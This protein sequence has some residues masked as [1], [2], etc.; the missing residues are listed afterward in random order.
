MDA[1]REQEIPEVEHLRQR[2]RA[3]AQGQH[4]GERVDVGRERG[5][6]EVGG[7][8]GVDDG[9]QAVHERE[10][11]VH[12]RHGG[13][14]V[15]GQVRGEEVV[16]EDVGF[17]FGAGGVEEGRG[18]DVHALQVDGG[19]VRRKGGAGRGGVFGWGQRLRVVERPGEGVE[20][21]D[22]GGFADASFE[23]RVGG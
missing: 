6:G 9:E 21:A 8:L 11:A 7:E 10:A 23:E 15:G 12:A 5:G 16:R 18:E 13:V 3:R 14:D 4:G 17:G 2:G 22:E 19:R 1:V 20:E